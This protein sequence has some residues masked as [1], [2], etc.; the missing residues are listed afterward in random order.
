VRI[1]D[2]NSSNCVLEHAPRTFRVAGQI[3]GF[4]ANTAALNR[5]GVF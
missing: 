4:R 1:D 3:L 5:R 2:S